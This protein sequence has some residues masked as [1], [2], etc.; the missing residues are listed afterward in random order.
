M[1]VGHECDTRDSTPKGLNGGQRMFD[2]P[3]QQ[4]VTS[5]I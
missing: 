4:V 3:I 1:I 2:F 5:P